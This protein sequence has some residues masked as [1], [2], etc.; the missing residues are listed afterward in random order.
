M[1]DAVKCDRYRGFYIPNSKSP[2][3]K[4]RKLKDGTYNGEYDLC[5]KC[6]KE[7]SLFMVNTPLVTEQSEEPAVVEGFK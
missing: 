5:P 2:R 1:A 3:I 4:I 6:L 7:F